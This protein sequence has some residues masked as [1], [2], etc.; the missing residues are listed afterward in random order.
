MNHPESFVII[1]FSV[2]PQDFATAK[3]G[4]HLS[5]GMGTLSPA[6]APLNC[7]T[8]KRF[9]QM[10]R[11][12]AR[13]A[14]LNAAMLVAAYAWLG[15]LALGLAVAAVPDVAAQIAALPV[16]SLWCAG[17]GLVFS[18]IAWRICP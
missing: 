17:A 7:N 6:S 1:H 14:R 8:P 2:S 15:V 16:A 11:A 3:S 12:T 10:P 4:R 5:L 18:A 9:T 13:L